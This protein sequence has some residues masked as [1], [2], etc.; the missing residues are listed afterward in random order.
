MLSGAECMF[1]IVSVLTTALSVICHNVAF[2][3]PVSVAYASYAKMLQE[4]Y[5][6]PSLDNMD[7]VVREHVY[8]IQQ[9]TSTLQFH[10]RSTVGDVWVSFED[11]Q[12][13]FSLLAKGDNSNVA[14]IEVNAE[15]MDTRRGMV[16]MLLN[17]IMV[18]MTRC[19][20]LIR[21]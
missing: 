16:K 7:V 17:L 21:V 13:D 1:K 4:E 20:N 8:K 18:L 15:K 11:F 14:S 19:F 9:E 12:G 10:V 5:Q 3:E 2:A 6:D